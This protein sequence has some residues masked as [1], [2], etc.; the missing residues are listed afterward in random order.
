MCIISDKKGLQTL[1]YVYFIYLFI[2]SGLEFTLT[3]LTHYLF[4]FTSMQQGWMFLAIGL[5]M[6][7]LQGGW[8]RTIPPN[9]TKSTAE[10]VKCFN[11]FYKNSNIH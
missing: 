3:F 8:V 7:I 9:K 10:L 1:G 5:I 6:A 2:Y 4:E 11:N